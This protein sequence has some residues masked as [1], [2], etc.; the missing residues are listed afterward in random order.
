[1]NGAYDGGG[2]GGPRNGA[3][4]SL[5]TQPMNL[6]EI[7]LVVSDEARQAHGRGG[8]Q[9]TVEAQMFHGGTNGQGQFDQLTGADG[10]AEVGRE[11]LAI[12]PT[13][14]MQHHAFC[15]AEVAGGGQLQDAVGSGWIA[16]FFSRNGRSRPQT[17]RVSRCRC[18]RCLRVQGS[19]CSHRR[20]ECSGSLPWFPL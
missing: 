8:I 1:M 5:G 15:A 4:D 2:P 9:R 6:H 10:G 7:D 16:H 3:T 13:H 19:G 14:Q 18:T 17:S 11:T 12:Q 20:G